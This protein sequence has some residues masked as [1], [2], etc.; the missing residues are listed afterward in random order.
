MRALHPQP[1]V[2]SW[3]LPAGHTGAPAVRRTAHPAGAKAVGGRNPE[4]KAPPLASWELEVGETQKGGGSYRKLT[5]DGL[6]TEIQREGDRDAG[7][8]R[9]RDRDTETEIWRD[10]DLGTKRDRDRQRVA[11]IETCRVQERHADRKVVRNSD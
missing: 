6:D 8:D 1:A 7:R 5:E 9:G 3:Q 10:G 11:E 4:G 2:V